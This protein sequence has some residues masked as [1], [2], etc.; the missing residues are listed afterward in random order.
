MTTTDLSNIYG[1]ETTLPIQQS[2]VGGAYLASKSGERFETRHPGNDRVIC[3]VEIAA[4][5]EVDKAV[6]AASVW[7]VD[8]RVVVRN[9]ERGDRS[10]E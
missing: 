10:G 5:Q 7:T 1:P 4:A 6:A 9:G 2:Y 3:E 8:V